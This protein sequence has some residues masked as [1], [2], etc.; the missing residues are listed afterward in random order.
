MRIVGNRWRSFEYT[1]VSAGP[2]AVA[3]APDVVGAT[4]TFVDC[5]L[6]NI[7]VEPGDYPLREHAVHMLHRA[8]TT[9]TAS[10]VVISATPQCAL[11]GIRDLVPAAGAIDVLTHVADTIDIGTELTERLSEH[12]QHVHLIPFGWRLVTRTD[13]VAPPPRPHCPHALVSAQSGRMRTF[14]SHR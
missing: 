7:V 3:L 6:V 10:S 14:R 1:P 4:Q 5:L 8:C 13:A 12:V 9:D 11:P 2:C